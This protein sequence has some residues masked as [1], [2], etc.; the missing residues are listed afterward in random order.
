MKKELD[1][2]EQKFTE[3]TLNSIEI[4]TRYY[5]DVLNRSSYQKISKGALLNVRSFETQLTGFKLGKEL[6]KLP[7]SIKKYSCLLF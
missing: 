7:K 3:I 6:T 1:I 5:H 2:L 4:E